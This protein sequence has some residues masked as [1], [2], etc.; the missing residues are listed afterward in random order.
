MCHVFTYL[1]ARACVCAV[2]A[3]ISED[4]AVC[5][6]L[7]RGHRNEFRYSTTAACDLFV[8]FIDHQVIENTKA[9]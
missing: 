7:P 3:V 9:L 8:I 2:D 4:S 5:V 1:G 6:D